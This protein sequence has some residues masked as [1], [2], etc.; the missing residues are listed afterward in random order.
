MILLLA[1]IYG[2]G[3][4]GV[5]WTLCADTKVIAKMAADF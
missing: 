5:L 3:T 2:R 4:Y 1:S